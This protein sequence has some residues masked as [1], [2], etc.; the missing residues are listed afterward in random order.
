M[1]AVNLELLLPSDIPAGERIL[2]HGRPQW[3]SLARRAFRADFVAGY[4]AL[5]ALAN[6]ALA[7]S[8]SLQDAML[9][10]AKTLGAGALALGLLMG[11]AWLAS[12]TTLY[13][14]TSRRVTMKIGIALPVFFNLPFS[15]IAAASLR[16]YGDG[17][18][19]IALELA[20]QT[21]IAYLHLWPHA[22][23]FR[24]ARPQP[25]LRCA[26]DASRV[27]ET[28]SRALIAAANQAQLAPAPE[29]APAPAPALYPDAVAA[30]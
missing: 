29:G 1:K 7:A 25:M 26:P 27:A 13:V 22:K 4:F 11:L 8:D 14:V 15:A 17:T 10:A 28:L 18:G 5:T 20:P 2:W 21:H 19:E 12:R 16:R 9:A 6:F 30:A 23:P 24:L 3:F